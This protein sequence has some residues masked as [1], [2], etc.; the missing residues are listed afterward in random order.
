MP[1][2]CLF[3]KLLVEEHLWWESVCCVVSQ[4]GHLLVGDYPCTEGVFSLWHPPLRWCECTWD[5]GLIVNTP[6][7]L[8]PTC[9]NETAGSY[10][11]SS[12]CADEP[13]HPTSKD[14]SA[15]RVSAVTNCIGSIL[16]SSCELE[17]EAVGCEFCAVPRQSLGLQPWQIAHVLTPPDSK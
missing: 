10:F 17:T 13:F 15:F 2:C 6:S 11:A 8:P 16:R 12:S 7:S 14:T 3:V 9:K 5:V 1:S 4:A